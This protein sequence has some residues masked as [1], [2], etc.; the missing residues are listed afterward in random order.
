MLVAVAVPLRSAEQVERVEVVVVE[1][2][3]LDRDLLER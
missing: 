1:T 2:A 3:L